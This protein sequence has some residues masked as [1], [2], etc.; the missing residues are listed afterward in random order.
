MIRN[1]LITVLVVGLLA[2]C[3]IGKR[4]NEFDVEEASKIEEGVTTKAEVRSKLGEPNTIDNNSNN[5]MWM[6]N[7]SEGKNYLE[8]FM[9]GLSGSTDFAGSTLII[10]FNGDVVQHYSLKT[11]RG[12]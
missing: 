2:G 12:N 6:Y 1:I 11:N 10:T 3:T 9:D 5:E 7:F 8:M 4:G